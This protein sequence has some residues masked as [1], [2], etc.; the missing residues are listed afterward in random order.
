MPRASK[1]GGLT[2][3][4]RRTYCMALSIGFVEL[5]VSD[6]HYLIL[7]NDIMQQSAKPIVSCKRLPKVIQTASGQ[8]PAIA[9][10]AAVF[11]DTHGCA[12]VERSRFRQFAIILVNIQQYSNEVRRRRDA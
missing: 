3:P 12:G 8:F 7:C 1:L 9:I 5:I 2:I 4:F 6:H 10:A 11:P